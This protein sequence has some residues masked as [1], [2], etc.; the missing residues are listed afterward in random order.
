MDFMSIPTLS[1]IDAQIITTHRITTRVLFS[2]S[3]G[4]PALFLHGNLMSATCWEEVMLDLPAGYWAI[5]PDQRGYGAADPSAKIHATQGMGELADDA[6]ALLDYLKIEQAH[7]IGHSMGGSVIWRLLIDYPERFL[8][9]TLVTPVPPYGFGATKDAIGA[10]CSPD[11]AGSGAGLI[12]PEMVKCF[13][14]GERGLENPLG[15]RAIFRGLVVKPPFIPAREEELLS[16]M[17]ATHLGERDFPGD[18]S[19]SSHWPYVAPGDWGPLNALSP[20]HAPQVENLYAAYP[21]TSI[22][23]IRGSHDLLISNRSAFDP[24]IAGAEGL[25]PGWPGDALYPPQPMLDQI[26]TVLENYAAAGGAYREVILQDTGH[27]PYLERPMAFNQ[28][29][30]RHLQA[31]AARQ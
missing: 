28:A 16:A 19:P 3:S 15:S 1:G 31:F 30:H 11:F 5:A 18:S 25:L 6:I 21:K 26:R 29:F 8:S 12:H 24:A 9:A 20:K 27:M 22:L 13:K 14:D 2:G 23:W 7:I 4:V 10:P 17:L